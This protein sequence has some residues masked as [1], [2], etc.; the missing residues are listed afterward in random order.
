MKK[1]QF[2]KQLSENG[3]N[4]TDGMIQQFHEYF[5]LLEKYNEVM[6]LTNVIDEEA[7]YERHFYDSLTPAFNDSFNHLKVCDVGS[8]AGFP[9]IP[10]KIVFPDMNLTI[11]DSMTKRMN[12]LKE[13]ITKLKLKNVNIV[14]GRVEETA[15]LYWEYFDIVTARAV[16]KLNMLLELCIPIVKVNGRFIALKGKNALDEVQNS[17]K[18]L[19]LLNVKL[20]KMQTWSTEENISRNN[21]FFTKIG[22]TNHKY[23]RKFSQIKSK[24][25]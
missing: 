21:L 12:F 16:A 23:P 6:D 13:V 25:L 5:L 14:I 19:K 17:T 7:V 11:I 4:L 24:P 1:E 18:A 20:L 9:A 15:N 2:I 3:I 10:L 8:G 22:S